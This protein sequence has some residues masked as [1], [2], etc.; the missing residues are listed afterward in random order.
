VGV[1]ED[2]AA[3]NLLQKLMKGVQVVAG[4]QDAVAPDCASL[5][6]NRRGLAEGFDVRLLEQLHRLDV[7]LAG[8]DCE[9]QEL[10]WV[11]VDVCE[12]REEA[13]L[14]ECV[15]LWIGVAQLPGMVQVGADALDGEEQ[16]VLQSRDGRLLS[17]YSPHCA[18]GA[19]CRLGALVTEHVRFSV[20]SHFSRLTSK[21]SE[22]RLWAAIHLVQSTGL[23]PCV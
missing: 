22:L 20:S 11:E 15:N 13:P 8:L 2:I 18:A 19:P 17:A 23:P 16:V 5:N 12:S 14:Y 6:L 7:H 3:L 4:D 10:L 21:F 1:D 9:P